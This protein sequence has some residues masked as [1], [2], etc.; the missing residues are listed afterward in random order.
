MRTNEPDVG[1]WVELLTLPWCAPLAPMSSLKRPGDA[2]GSALPS[3]TLHRAQPGS[4]EAGAERDAISRKRRI[5]TLDVQLAQRDEPV[6]WARYASTRAAVD[7]VTALVAST[8]LALTGWM[9]RLDAVWGDERL[10]RHAW[11]AGA[12]RAVAPCICSASAC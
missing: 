10:H 8:L 1:P 7:G 11:L 9:G 4:A 12:W 6:T 3:R 5:G 2:L